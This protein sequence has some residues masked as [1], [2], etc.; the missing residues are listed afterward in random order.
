LRLTSLQRALLFIVGVP[1]LLFVVLAARG[2]V[3][4][5]HATTTSADAADIDG[6]GVPDGSDNCP[7]WPNALQGLPDWSVPAGDSDCDGFP[8]TLRAGLRTAESDFGTDSEKHCAVTPASNDEPGSDAWPVD[9]NDDQI[10]KGS[11]ILSFASVL[12]EQWPDDGYDERFDINHDAKI[13]GT[14]ML[15]LAPFFGKRCAPLVATPTFTPTPTATATP[16]TTP[17]PTPTPTTT[18]P[19]TPTPTVVPGCPALAIQPTGTPIVGPPPTN[20]YMLSLLTADAAVDKLTE[21]ATVPG[22]PGRAVIISEPGRIWK[23]CLSNNAPRE[24]MAD[25]TDIV[26]DFNGTNES[27]EG[28]VGFAFD[29][30]DPSYVFVDYSLGQNYLGAT[31]L[32]NTVRSRVSRFHLVNGQVDRSSERIIIEVYQPWEYHNA[33][34]L[35]FG[36]DG[37]L[38][39]GVGDGGGT[40]SVAQTVNELWGSI[41][42]I[43]VHS[44]DPYAIPSG[45]PFADGPGGNADEVWAYG[46]RN[47]WRFSFD[48]DR[49]WLTD[50]GESKYEEVNIGQAGA[51]YGWP[52]ME[53]NECFQPPGAPTPT[54]VPTCNTAGLA[55]PRFAYPHAGNGCAITGGYVYHGA[56]MPELDGYYIYG[57]WCS[58]RIWAL[59]ADDDLAAPI[60][61]TDTTVHIV[62]W[63]LTAQGE[64]LAVNYARPDFGGGQAPSG[65]Y[66]LRRFLP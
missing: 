38:Y 28:L 50:V 17:M 35:V 42:R 10:L 47:P 5:L 53:G 3:P 32:A 11:D 45:N 25:L 18:L 66:E 58:G 30:I 6:D 41:L 54:P 40:S 55:T 24:L 1:A 62:S 33:D 14:D 12:G 48:G 4:G 9:W 13:A 26:R 20:R 64:I 31:P 21:I 59:A 37:M 22:D 36:P 16:T 46:L 27:D 63:G 29:P 52:I 2:G 61:L 56:S 8:D 49:M 23:V 43:D 34:G 60:Q 57:D 51:N 19:P 44:G 15:L 39:I 65:I 7:A